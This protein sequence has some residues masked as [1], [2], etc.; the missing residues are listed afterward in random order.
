MSLREILNSNNNGKST[1]YD[2]VKEIDQLTLDLAIMIDLTKEHSHERTVG[3][4]LKSI[5]YKIQQKEAEF[6]CLINSKIDRKLKH[7]VQQKMLENDLTYKKLGNIFG[8]SGKEIKSAIDGSSPDALI[9]FS[10]ICKYLGL[11]EDVSS[12]I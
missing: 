5:T 2:I 1:Y 3:E 11:K 6:N 12:C 8:I 9:I 10:E 7:S 4:V